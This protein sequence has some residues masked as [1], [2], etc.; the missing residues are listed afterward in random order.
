MNEARKGFTSFN[1]E[2][3]QAGGEND[4]MVAEARK[5]D[6]GEWK[7]HEKAT[8]T[9]TITT[10]WWCSVVSSHIKNT[11]RD[12]ENWKET[13][14]AYGGVVYQ[15]IK[16]KTGRGGM[17]KKKKEDKKNDSTVKSN[18]KKGN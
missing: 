4:S 5:A 7:E 10:A 17:Q 2:A 9:T 3:L 12:I 8:R 6:D 14:T 11:E 15:D 13:T 1:W 16:K 18:I